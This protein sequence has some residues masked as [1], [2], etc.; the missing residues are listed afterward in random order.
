MTLQTDSVVGTSVSEQLIDTVFAS[1]LALDATINCK[2]GRRASED[3]SGPHTVVA[4]PLGAPTIDNV[5]MKPGGSPWSTTQGR[6]LMIRHFRIE[7]RCHDGP[8]QPGLIPDF[9]NA[10]ALYL[11]VLVAIRQAIDPSG[12]PFHNAVQFEDERWDDQ[13]EGEDSYE[14][15]GTLIKFFTVMDLPVYDAAPTMVPL[16]A[17]P[18]IVTTVTQQDQTVTINQGA[19]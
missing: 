8:T 15:N 3:Y 10:E 6:Q 17:N 9:T 19:T 14:R 7:W 13:Q 18:P 5:N 16:T 2:L 11:N 12:T 4:I 1:L